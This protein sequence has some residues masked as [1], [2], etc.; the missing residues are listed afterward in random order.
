MMCVM[1]KRYRTS[2]KETR[3]DKG[4][5]FS[6]SVTLQGN[7]FCSSRKWVN[8]TWE[9]ESSRVKTKHH[10]DEMYHQTP[11]ELSDV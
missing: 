2:C 8:D 3:L 7:Q 4:K 10:S 6:V 1:S 11:A 9:T 5:G